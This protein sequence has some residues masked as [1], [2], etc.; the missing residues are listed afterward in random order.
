[1]ARWDHARG[2]SISPLTNTESRSQPRWQ[3]PSR[4]RSLKCSS[5]NGKW[6]YLRISLASLVIPDERERERSLFRP[7]QDRTPLQSLD[8]TGDQMG[9]HDS[10]CIRGRSTGCA[11]RTTVHQC[12]QICW[13]DV[14]WLGI[15]CYLRSVCSNWVSARVLSEKDNHCSVGDMRLSW[16][17]VL[18]KV[19][20]LRMAKSWHLGCKGKLR[21]RQNVES[22]RHGMGSA[23]SSMSVMFRIHPR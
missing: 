1:M 18:R 19:V 9:R 16:I 22:H 20:L 6:E 14:V 4:L 23:Q 7:V 13:V 10:K 3:R 15:H 11:P 17:R 12:Y 21:R 2:V 5:T 8:L